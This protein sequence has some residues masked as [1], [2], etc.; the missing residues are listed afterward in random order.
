MNDKNDEKRRDAAMGREIYNMNLGWKFHD[1]DIFERNFGAIHGD[2]YQNPQWVKAGNNGVAK[3]GY[4][5]TEWQDVQLPHDFVHSR[6]QYS[7][8]VPASLGSL[9]K[10]IGWYRKCFELPKEDEGKILSIEFD[11]V[12]RDCSVWLNGHFL[13]RNLNG[14]NSFAFDM[15]DVANYGGINVVAVRVDATENEGWWYEGGGIYRDVRLVKTDRLH[16]PQWGTFVMTDLETNPH[17]AVVTIM[18]EVYNRYE[19]EVNFDLSTKII[20]PSG[21]K[22]D[23]VC[24]ASSI[25][26]DEQLQ[27]EQKALV[28]YPKLWSIDEPQLYKA[29]SIL[30]K[31]GRIVDTYETTFGIRTVHFDG[32]RG[33]LLNGAPVKLK[34]VCC[35][36]DHAGV[37]MAMPKAVIDYRIQRLKEM[38]C[39]AY[40]TSHNPPSPWLLEACDRLGMVVIDEVRQTGTS[41]EARNHLSC[42]IRRDRNHPSV[43]LWSLG[44]EEMNIQGTPAG[45]RILQR[46]QRLAHQ[47]DPTRKCTYAMNGDWLRMTEFHEEHGFHIDVHGFNYMMLRDWEAYAKFREKYPDRCLVGTENASTLSTRGLYNKEQSGIQLKLSAHGESTAIWLNPKRKGVV[48]AYGE[49]YPLWG[50]TPEEGWKAATE[51]DY[52]AGL[53]VWTGFDY[54]GETFPYEWPTVVSQYGIMDLCGFAKDIYYYLN[55]RSM[56]WANKP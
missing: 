54:R 7:P 45:V 31:D 12:Y 9:V 46:M 36:E 38:G 35:H 20:D 19:Q 32:D 16:V 8:E 17:Q 50:A 1:G 55:F 10:G 48:T 44:N 28:H 56:K 29:V 52:V 6:G 47:L 26:A 14:Y 42:L 2:R 11:G 5:D 43:I 27:L 37:G 30:K 24:T 22:I 21:Q 51:H 53:F 39:N 41:E 34:G 33:F 40:R 49:T 3:A 18:T 4:D 13:G 15:T 25:Q 23:E